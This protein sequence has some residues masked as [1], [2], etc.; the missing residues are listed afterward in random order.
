MRAMPGLIKDRHGTY[1]AQRKVPE[2]LQ[3][4]VARVLNSEKPKQVF[5]KKS[6]GTKNFK[7]ANV[8]AT[9]FLAEFNRTLASAEALL[10]DRP[11]IASLIDV[12][13]KR[14]IAW[15][16]KHDDPIVVAFAKFLDDGHMMLGEDAFSGRSD[17]FGAMRFDDEGAKTAVVRLDDNGVAGRGSE[18]TG[19]LDRTPTF[20]CQVL[21]E[22]IREEGQLS[23]HLEAGLAKEVARVVLVLRNGDRSCAVDVEVAGSEEVEIPVREDHPASEF[24]LGLE[25][26][27][28][29]GLLGDS[30]Q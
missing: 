13:I 16:A 7:E 23:R 1:Y 11:I 19:M 26:N 21:G 9:L 29:P 15:I 17:I 8:A 18:F 20:G 4:A 27:A 3:E 25:F 14:M 30:G 2:H 24:K 22:I 10:K 12:Q 5:L 6:L 28:N